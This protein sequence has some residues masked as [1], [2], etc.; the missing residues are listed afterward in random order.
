[1]HSIPLNA[2]AYKRWV[3]VSFGCG[4]G[5]LPVNGYG[6][7]GHALEFVQFHASAA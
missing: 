3:V 7:D 4:T 2:Y 1:M 5:I 6:Q